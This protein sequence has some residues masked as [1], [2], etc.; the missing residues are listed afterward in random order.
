MLSVFPMTS[1]ISVAP[2]GVA[3]M[4]ETAILMHHITT[5]VL[6]DSA[7]AIGVRAAK[8]E[9]LSNA[10]SFSRISRAALRTEETSEKSAILF[11]LLRNSSLSY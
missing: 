3:L 5:P 10:S 4:P 1:I 2:P 11:F 7:S 9:S 6:I 8:R